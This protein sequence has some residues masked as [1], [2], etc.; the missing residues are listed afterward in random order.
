M[1]VKDYAL[2]L[3][4]RNSTVISPNNLNTPLES[5]YHFG[6]HCKLYDIN[7]EKILIFLDDF[8]YLRKPEYLQKKHIVTKNEIGRIDKISYKYYNT[9]ELWWLLAE[10]NYIDPFE[11]YE[12]QELLIPNLQEFDFKCMIKDNF[13][14]R[15]TDDF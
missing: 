4:K 15:N 13:Q 12:G 10:V 1:K 8:S 5:Y 2:T 7:K 3:T 6:S 11:L 9:P 14:S